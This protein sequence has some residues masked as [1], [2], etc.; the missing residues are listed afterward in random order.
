MVQ[1]EDYLFGQLRGSRHILPI[2]YLAGTFVH[3][4][5]LYY[6]GS[7]DICVCVCFCSCASFFIFGGRGDAVDW[8]SVEINK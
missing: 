7:W 6:I 3:V 4:F 1:L 8:A 5:C 2:L